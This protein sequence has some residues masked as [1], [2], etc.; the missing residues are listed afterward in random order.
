MWFSA[1]S[2][3]IHKTMEA[4]KGWKFTTAEYFDLLFKCIYVQLLTLKTW[5]AQRHP[6]TVHR[7]VQRGKEVLNTSTFGSKYIFNEAVTDQVSVTNQII[8]KDKEIR[9]NESRKRSFKSQE[10]GWIPSVILP[11]LTSVT[12]LE[13]CFLTKMFNTYFPC[14]RNTQWRRSRKF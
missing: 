12:S 10:S 14:W 1:N 4:K 11:S 8:H 2:I 9:T 6:R 3:Q 7:S 13:K 5:R